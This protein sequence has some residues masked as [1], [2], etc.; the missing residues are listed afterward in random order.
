M[1]ARFQCDAYPIYSLAREHPD[2]D[3]VTGESLRYWT[4]WFGRDR[5][6]RTKGR[7]WV[8]TGGFR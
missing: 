3:A 6:G 5:E 8:A 4:K 7:V 1:L 2:Y